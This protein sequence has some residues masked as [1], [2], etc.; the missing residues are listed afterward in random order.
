VL[1][2]PSLHWHCWL[3]IR[4]SIQFVEK[5]SCEV[6][7]WL[8]VWSKV[9]MI[10]IQ[11]SWCHCHPVISCFIKIQ[12]GLTFL[13]MAYPGYSEK[14]GMLFIQACTSHQAVWC[15]WMM[16]CSCETNH[17]FCIADSVVYLHTGS[18]VC[19]SDVRMPHMLCRIMLWHVYTY[20]QVA[21]SWWHS[22]AHV[23]PY[24]TR[25]Y[26]CPVEG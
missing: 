22:V 12:N 5:L 10:C 2:V 24:C 15:G 8:S 18:V 21:G 26:N 25:C 4:K 11:S 1:I 6:L 13:V 19:V 14:R 3:G 23:S 20:S 17:T 16:V 9:Q 7:A